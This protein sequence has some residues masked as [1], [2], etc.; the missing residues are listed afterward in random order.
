[1]NEYLYLI[2]VTLA[3]IFVLWV[4]WNVLEIAYRVGLILF[5]S[6]LYVGITLIEWVTA[7]V[8]WTVIIPIGFLLR[9]NRN[10]A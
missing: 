7:L 8:R 6:V 3:S 5:H 9:L 10:R 2:P 1:M 4:A